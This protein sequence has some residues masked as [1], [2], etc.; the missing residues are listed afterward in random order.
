MKPIK[1]LLAKR[2]FHA[3]NQPRVTEPSATISF[4]IRKFTVRPKPDHRN[5]VVIPMFCEFGCEVMGVLYCIPHLLQHRYAGKYVIVVGWHGREYLYRHLADEFWELN[6]ESQWLREHARAFHHE[7]EN[8]RKIEEKLAE[9]V[10]TVV[11]ADKLSSLA[12]YPVLETCSCGGE[13][14]SVDD[15]QICATCFVGYP[16]PGYFNRIQ[17]AQQEAR[18]LPSPSA[19]AIQVAQKYISR[20]AVGLTARHRKTYGRNLPSIFYERLIY[21]IEDLGYEPIWIG[22]PTSTL[23]C[24]LPRIKDFSKSIDASNLEITLALVAQLKFTIQFWTASTRLAG[25]VGTPFII[26][27]SPDQIWGNGQEGMRLNLCSNGPRKLVVSHFRNCLEN[28]S[29]TLAL[30]K[31]AIHGM[32]KG[33]YRDIIGLVESR[34]IVDEIKRQNTP[35]IGEPR[36]KT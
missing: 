36:W 7:S 10:G 21:L 19:E 6:K 27:E 16:R 14:R 4:Q 33:D 13:I 35:R 31:Q 1:K 18:W 30:V 20:P 29:A 34:D 28:Q 17:S 3:D 15:R 5:C 12:V 23:S 9:T 32:E 22:E 2:E 25:L 11:G 26:F 24:P 8:L